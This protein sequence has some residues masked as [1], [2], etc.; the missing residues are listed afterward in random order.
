MRSHGRE[1]GRSLA[2]RGIAVVQALRGTQADVEGEV[3]QALHT[4]GYVGGHP[5]VLEEGRGEDRPTVV[6]CAVYGSAP[7]DAR[8]MEADLGE[9]WPTWSRPPR[10][11]DVVAPC[12]HGSGAADEARAVLREVAEGGGRIYALDERADG[13]LRAVLA[14]NGPTITLDRAADGRATLHTTGWDGPARVVLGPLDHERALRVAG[15]WPERAAGA[16]GCTGAGQG[17]GVLVVELE[18][19][20]GQA[21][22]EDRIR[23]A[24]GAAQ[25]TGGEIWLAAEGRVGGASTFAACAVGSTAEVEPRRLEERMA[26]CWPGGRLPLSIRCVPRAGVTE[27][28]ARRARAILGRWEESGPEADGAYVRLDGQPTRVLV[29]RDASGLVQVEAVRGDARGVVVLDRMDR[30]LAEQVAESAWGISPA[31]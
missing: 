26:R 21:P 22:A 17:P 1:E 4:A 23:A 10:A 18:E 5:R 12:R 28:D 9:A 19:G 3:R 8:R 25:C 6:A 16:P 2:V 30:A 13:G 14:G 24:L 31:A 15:R 27:A 29:A 7:R 20:S 11:L